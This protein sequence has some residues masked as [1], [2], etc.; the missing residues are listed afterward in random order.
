M[1]WIKEGDKEPREIPSDIDV[2]LNL[3]V[4]DEMKECNIEKMLAKSEESLGG[5]EV[6]TEQITKLPHWLFVKIQRVDSTGRKK[7]RTQVEPHESIDLIQTKYNLNA[8]IKHGSGVA[9]NSGHFNSFV[10]LE[11]SQ[12]EK[13]WFWFNDGSK[14]VELENY[15]AVFRCT[16]AQ[17]VILSYQLVEQKEQEEQKN[18]R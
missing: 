12:K 15:W 11:K 5:N 10:L 18:N 4:N 7:I 14:V 3:Y 1:A 8:I 6:R 16:T 17:T 2:G 13:K 9:A